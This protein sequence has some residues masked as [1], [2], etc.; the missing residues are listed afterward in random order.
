MSVRFP[1]RPRFCAAAA[2]LAALGSAGAAPSYRITVIPAL[3]GA[4]GCQA[5]ALNASNQV[6]GSCARR[7]YFWSEAGGLVEIAP[8]AGYVNAKAIN[9]AGRVVGD[10]FRP[11][12]VDAFAWTVER[13]MKVFTRDA[14]RANGSVW[15]L[16]DRNQVVGE[17]WVPAP[18]GHGFVWTPKRG[19]VDPRPEA[20]WHT[21]ARA[22]NAS[23]QVAGW[24]D[25]PRGSSAF[26]AE[27]GG[28]FTELVSPCALPS[29][30]AYTINDL[31]QVGGSCF[32][33]PSRI[34]AAFWSTPESGIDIDG[35][36]ELGVSHAFSLNDAGQIIGYWS[37]RVGEKEW[38]S[39]FY[40]DA[41]TGM[42][43]LDTLIDPSDPLRP[44]VRIVA[45]GAAI[46]AAGVVAA[47]GLVDGAPRGLLLTPLP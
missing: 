43:D 13:G 38:E 32:P 21:T 6:I 1:L 3:P 4:P 45:A 20:P 42:V 30:V 33:D 8:R 47:T 22:I 16:N 39:T 24:V 9:A 5:V 44:N 14:L 26:I 28:R 41:A 29:T 11:G 2:L 23:G 25:G 10:V 12:R 15:G 36:S 27:G 31:G 35:R 37:G 34:H 40:W 17:G 19:F 18:P 7:S 46:N